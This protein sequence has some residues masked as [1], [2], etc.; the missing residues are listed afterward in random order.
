[1]A[2]LYEINQDI[3]NCI[4][5]ETGEI[6]DD[7]K[8]QELQME[9]SEKIENIALWIK[10][11]ES[12]TKAIKDEINVLRERNELKERKIEKLKQYLTGNVEKKF[13]TSKVI[14]SYRKSVSVNITDESKLEE[15]YIKTKIETSVDKMAIKEAI[16]NGITVSGAELIEKQNIQIK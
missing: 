10:N 1:M 14:I 13:E 4:D 12:E 8:L 7:E 3:M 16:K 15:K 6:L 11:L 9:K 5:F 2:S